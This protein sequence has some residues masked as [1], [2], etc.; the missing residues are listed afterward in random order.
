MRN[1]IHLLLV[2][3]SFIV[4]NLFADFDEE[5][6]TYTIDTLTFE[7]P[8]GWTYEEQWG[9]ESFYGPTFTTYTTNSGNIWIYPE[10]EI[11]VTG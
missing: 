1:F 4:S 6:R 7:I 11:S 2:S 10:A 8:Q 5:N 3:L 9:R